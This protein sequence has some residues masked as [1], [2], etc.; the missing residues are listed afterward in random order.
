MS[1]VSLASTLLRAQRA[2]T[3]LQE[4]TRRLKDPLPAATVPQ[5]NTQYQDPQHVILVVVLVSILPPLEKVPSFRTRVFPAPAT[6][7]PPSGVPRFPIANVRLV[8]LDRMEIRVIPVQQVVS[9]PK[10]VQPTG[11]LLVRRRINGPRL[12]VF[13]VTIAW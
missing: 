2:S 6:Q 5:E 10:L 4:S 9:R 7:S 8:S 12:K 13:Q 11:A 1:H 3:V